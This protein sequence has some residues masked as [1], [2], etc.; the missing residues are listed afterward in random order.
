MNLPLQ[1]N[2]RIDRRALS[3][4]TDGELVEILTGT[5]MLQWATSGVVS[6]GVESDWYNALYS[7]LREPYRAAMHEAIKRAVS[8][9]RRIIIT[10]ECGEPTYQ[11]EAFEPERGFRLRMVRDGMATF[12]C[13]HRFDLCEPG[14][15]WDGDDITVQVR[16]Y[17]GHGS[18]AIAQALNVALEWWPGKYWKS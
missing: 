11:V 6:I 4:L 16:E 17:E 18:H 10:D 3:D 2:E 8:K 12:M 14:D 1:L 15:V 9:G 13:T 5:E 7:H